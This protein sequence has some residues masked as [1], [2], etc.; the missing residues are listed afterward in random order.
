[1]PGS[2]EHT[3]AEPQSRDTEST[4]PQERYQRKLFPGS[5]HTWAL[6][7]LESLPKHSHVLDVGAGSG[8]MGEALATLGVESTVAVEP[9][10]AARAHSAHWY[11]A[12]YAALSEVPQDKQ[13]DAL[14]LLDVIEHVS[15]P[16]QMLRDCVARL[17]PGGALLLSVPNIAHWSIR[18]SL[19]FGFFEYTERGIL[20]RTHLSFFTRR[21]VSSMLRRLPEIRIEEFCA[22]IPPLEFLLPDWIVE[23][24]PYRVFRALHLHAARLLPGIFGYQHLV[25]LRRTK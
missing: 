13:F 15:N 5:S 18:L 24:A 19:L 10:D 4:P 17:A 8:V 6:R 2:T 1:M 7:H 23:S 20:D 21:R 16:E 14:L 9:H 25:L 12:S 3:Q 22:S 11:R